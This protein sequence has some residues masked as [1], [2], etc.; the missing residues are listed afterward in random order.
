MFVGAPNANI[1]MPVEKMRITNLDAKSPP[2]SFEVLY[3]PQ[4]YTRKK[5]VT[6]GEVPHLGAD[7]PIV[8]F[9]SG[10]KEVLSFELFFD[11]VSAGAEVGGTVADRVKFE[12]SSIAPTAAGVIDVRDYTKK[13]TDLMY[14]DSDLHRPPVLKVEWS[15]L[16][17]KGFL[18]QCDQRFVRFNENGQPVR[19]I[20]PAPSSSSGTWRSSMWPIP[21]TP[22]IRRNTTPCARGIPSGPWPRRNTATRG[23][24]G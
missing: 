16:Q 13:L 21:S 11:S 14:I 3:N 24:G 5:T 12:A 20:L 10:A 4:S 6:Y 15:S 1:L 2:K 17:F 23:C 7:A 8:Q 18:A 9:Q 22:R 19:A